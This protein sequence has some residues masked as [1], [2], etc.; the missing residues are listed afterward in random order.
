MAEMRG[1]GC[2]TAPPGQQTPTQRG[3][4]PLPAARAGWRKQE[5][6]HWASKTWQHTH[7]S[8]LAFSSLQEEAEVLHSRNTRVLTWWIHDRSRYVVLDLWLL[9]YVTPP[10]CDSVCVCVSVSVCLSPPNR[11][12]TAPSR[13][14]T[15]LSCLRTLTW[16]FLLSARTQLHS[17][18]SDNSSPPPTNP[19][20]SF[21]SDTFSCCLS[22]SLSL[23]L[24]GCSEADMR[25]SVL[26]APC[27]CH[28]LR[29]PP[30]FKKNTFPSK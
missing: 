3:G 29:H 17:H 2:S 15:W 14:T 20:R 7:A 28:R 1:Q 9:L 10:V 6:A 25:S 26:L 23:S 16:C 30:R 13:L 21:V 27:C 19:A 22:L 8:Q 24:S 4:E 11:N 18:N 12:T 5:A